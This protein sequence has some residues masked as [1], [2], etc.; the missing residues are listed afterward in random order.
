MRR[1]PRPNSTFFRATLAMALL[2]W[3]TFAFGMPV[4]SP[5]G[6]HARMAP[7]HAQVADTSANCHDMQMA[8]GG[9][10]H[11]PVPAAPM[12]HG[13]CCHA[14]CHCLFTCNAVL[15]VPF[16]QPGLSPP[17]RLVPTPRLVHVRPAALAPPLRPPIA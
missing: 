3:T 17:D 7:P 11:H 8:S 4:I 13:D 6:D 9:S 12:G 16:A 15:A 1:L 2:A 14:G 5:S 10:H